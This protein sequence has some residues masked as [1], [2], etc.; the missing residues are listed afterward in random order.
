MNHNN[1]TSVSLLARVQ[2]DDQDAWGRLLRLYSPLVRY[3]CRRAGIADADLDDVGQEVFRAVASGIGSFQGGRPG[4]TFRGWLRGVCRHKILDHRRRQHLPA[5]E[6]GTDA[7]L[8]LNQLAEPELGEETA[9]EVSGLYRRALELVR[10]EFEAR[11]WDMFWRAAIEGHPPDLIAAE[12]GV[13]AAAVR[14]AKSR[15][16]LRLREEVGDLID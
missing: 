1:T 12:M 9:E 3:W 8:R 11:T 4:D 5:A 6:G 10:G 7:Q 13:S 16:L 15:V 14:K 2:A